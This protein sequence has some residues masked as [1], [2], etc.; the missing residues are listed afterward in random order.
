MTSSAEIAPAATHSRKSVY[1]VL[2]STLFAAAGQ[3]L[4]KFG[5][6]YHMPAFDLHSTATWG[7]FALA[8][9]ANYPLLLG[10]F[11]Q[12]G[13]ALLLI[14]A[15]RDGELS[16]L[17]PIISLTYVWVG[18]LSLYFFHEQT[19]LWKAMGIALIVCGVGLLGRASSQPSSK[20]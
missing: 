1:L 13:T 3:I 12:S 10:Y 6:G 15:L 11:V 14:L 18:L 8:L 5:T 9:L 19:N 4:M 17:F 2:G 20:A 16:I 7:P